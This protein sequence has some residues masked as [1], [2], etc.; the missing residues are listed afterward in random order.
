MKAKLVKE[1]LNESLT[2]IILTSVAI[3]CLYRFLKGL[4]ES[5]QHKYTRL[6]AKSLR[7]I[8][9]MLK[10][11]LDEPEKAPIYTD[12]YWFHKITFPTKSLFKNYIIKVNKQTKIMT[13]TISSTNVKDRPIYLT[14]EQYNEFL[15]II[16]KIKE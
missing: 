10:L 12:D 2:T 13:I 5:P 11:R 8:Y 16:D 3:Y 7:D 1:S 4:L 14:D 9:Y 15:N 6:A